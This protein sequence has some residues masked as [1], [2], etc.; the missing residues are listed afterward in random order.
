[1]SRS[2]TIVSNFITLQPRIL[3][4][5]VSFIT[6]PILLGTTF[7][8]LGITYG[9]VDS[10]TV[11]IIQVN[12]NQSV[13][14]VLQ[15]TFLFSLP[16]TLAIFSFAFN[17]VIGLIRRWPGIATKMA[18]GRQGCLNTLS[19]SLIKPHSTRLCDSVFLQPRRPLAIEHSS[20][21]MLK[22]SDRAY[23]TNTFY[24]VSSVSCF[25]HTFVTAYIKSQFT[26]PQTRLIW[27]NSINSVVGFLVVIMI[28][29][30]SRARFVK[31]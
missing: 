19:Q 5:F 3:I 16:F 13:S 25:T 4:V 7:F 1:M 10:C 12:N 29:A 26:D 11:L 27:A 31:I 28:F 6:S 8:F 23:F 14:K 15:S 9:V 18:S 30:L 21:Q 20:T 17:L 24:A 22:T 2:F